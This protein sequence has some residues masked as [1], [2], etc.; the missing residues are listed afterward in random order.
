MDIARQVAV[1]MPCPE[2]GGVFHVSLGQILDA[3]E[4]MRAACNARG[5]RECP[6]LYYAHLV[7]RDSAREMIE[8]AKRMEQEAEAA[9]GKLVILP[10]GPQRGAH[11]H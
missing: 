10:A 1:E 7:D 8:A 11:S 2:C 3:Q 9:G 6:G 5:P 4:G